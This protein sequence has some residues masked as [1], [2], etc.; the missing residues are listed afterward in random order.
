MLASCAG[1]NSDV[2]SVS[3][4]YPYELHK[5]HVASN[6]HIT[7]TKI[8]PY[9]VAEPY[10]LPGESTDLFVV[11]VSCYQKRLLLLQEARSFGIEKCIIRKPYYM[12][13]YINGS[14]LIIDDSS[15]STEWIWK[16]FH[17][18]NNA[19]KTFIQN[20]RLIAESLEGVDFFVVCGFI[21]QMWRNHSH[22]NKFTFPLSP[23][24]SLFQIRAAT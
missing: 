22:K 2:F 19:Y 20:N 10:L 7:Q 3:S 11:S 18:F 5:F 13:I 17:Q 15:S 8:K 6:N 9:R 23:S 21:V 4:Q 12:Q 1:A 16:S 14:T 24:L